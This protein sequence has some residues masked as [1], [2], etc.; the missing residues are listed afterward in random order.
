MLR[1]LDTFAGRVIALAAV[2]GT[3]GL[4]AEVVVILI[5]VI[6]RY[7]GSPLRGA[8]DVTQMAMVVLVFGGMALCDR[9]GGHIAVDLFERSFPNWLNKL[10]DIVAAVLGALVFGL[11]AWNMWKS[12]SIS[13]MLNL[14]TNIINLP[15]DWFQYYVVVCSV[16]TAAGM[17]LR[18]VYLSLGG[19]VT[20]PEGYNS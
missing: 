15:K 6:G 4:L 3:L 16:I 12:A 19:S 9:Q 18:A 13:Q 7:F 2:L 10:T 5:D 20:R 14:S 17:T 1:T 8:Q 11:I